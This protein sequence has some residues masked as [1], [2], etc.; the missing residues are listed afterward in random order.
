MLI[1]SFFLAVTSLPLPPRHSSGASEDSLYLKPTRGGGDASRERE[2][3]RR[4]RA[5]L[6]TGET[7]LF[8]GRQPVRYREG[9]ETRGLECGT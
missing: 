4:G 1:R 7:R 6:N 9:G 5:Y 2:G 3:E 8:I